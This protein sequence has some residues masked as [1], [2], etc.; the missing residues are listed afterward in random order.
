MFFLSQFVFLAMPFN[1][2][3]LTFTVMALMFGALFNTLTRPVDSGDSTA[4]RFK[5]KLANLKATLLCGKC[6]RKRTSEGD[7]KEK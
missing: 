5:R 4:D 7:A 2:M 1:V 6:A 3:L